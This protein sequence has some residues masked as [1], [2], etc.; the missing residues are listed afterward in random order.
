M[1]QD[2]STPASPP[3]TPAAQSQEL[4]DAQESS[5]APSAPRELS[6][7]INGEVLDNDPPPL[8]VDGRVLIPLRKVFNALGA[9][10]EYKDKVITAR[11]G[12]QVV[13]LQPE[14]TDASIAGEPV[15][16]DVPPQLVD[17]VTYVPLRFVAQ[18]LGDEVAYDG[19]TR[20][21]KVTPAVGLAADRIDELK[22]QVR[23]LAVGNQG[24]ILKLWDAEL[25][26]EIYYRGLDDRATAP[27]SPDDH[28]GL[29]SGMGLT[30]ELELF[31]LDLMEGYSKLPKK[32]VVAFL[33]LVHSIPEKTSYGF[34]ESTTR[35]VQDFLLEVLAEDPD[36][37]TRRQAALSLAVG[38][39]LDQVI[40]DA[41]LDFYSGSSNLWETFPVQQFFQFQATKIRAMP[42]HALV[43][44][45]VADV[46][47]LYTQPIL[48]YLDGEMD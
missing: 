2:G 18:A 30:E 43:R 41:V 13:V 16:L 25:A 47:S 8:T 27:Y 45:R 15:T 26:K 24:A 19:A 33:G 22:G 28:Q 42:N 44:S 1:A 4:K 17:G 21:I 40:L 14:V 37:V 38:A 32:E 39:S 11:R 5:P 12:D 31:T 7:V 34:Q 46:N 10:V 35:Q 20:T 48:R 9:E 23:R 6:I 29:V 3:T 36:V